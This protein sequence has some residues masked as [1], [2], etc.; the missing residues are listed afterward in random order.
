MRKVLI[1][2]YVPPYNRQGYDLAES[3]RNSGFSVRLF[4]QDGEDN[5]EKQIKGIKIIR[6]HGFFH[7]VH[8]LHNFLAFFFNTLFFS[9]QIVI[10]VGRPMLVLGAI[11]KIVFGAKLIWYSLEFTNLRW[12]DRFIYRN[13]VSGY[14]DVEENR[15]RAIFNQY[16]DKSAALVIYNM[17]H[18]M[19]EVI[20]GKLRSY[21]ATK[22]KVQSDEKLIVFAGSYQTYACPETMLAASKM[23]GQGRRLI[24]ML[25]GCPDDFK[26]DNDQ[27]IIIPPVRGAEFYEWLK[28]ADCA[29]LPYEDECDFNVMNCSPQK[30]FDCFAVGIPFVVSDR[31]IARKLYSDLPSCCVFCDFTDP[32]DIVK[33]VNVAVDLKSEVSGKMIALHHS[34]YNY[35]NMSNSI[36]EL[37]EKV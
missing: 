13:C 35:D 22:Y 27:C 16:G 10:C 29:L 25:F 15:Q 18:Y 33:K 11:Y 30:I 32:D 19:D 5:A 2:S 31:P 9:K 21:L 14:I 24:M 1:I 23:F 12:L 37:I 7:K 20:G 4:Q 17:P 3:L 8:S 6:A 26:S 36:C 34:K 28:D